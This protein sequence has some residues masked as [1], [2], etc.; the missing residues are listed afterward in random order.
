MFKVSILTRYRVFLSENTP[1]TILPKFAY[2]SDH[3][4]SCLFVESFVDPIRHCL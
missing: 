1:T 2:F 4:S 3:I